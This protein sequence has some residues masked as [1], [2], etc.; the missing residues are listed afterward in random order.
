MV[1]QLDKSSL[2]GPFIRLLLI[3]PLF[4]FH[5]INAT[6]TK[7]IHYSSESLFELLAANFALY[8]NDQEASLH[9]YLS[10][11]RVQ[12]TA[13]IAERA[14]QLALSQKRY[15]AMLE[16]AELW[17]KAS[18]QDGSALFFSSLASALNNKGLQALIYMSEAEKKGHPTDYTRIVKLLNDNALIQKAYRNHLQFV[19][20]PSAKN[21]DAMIALCLLLALNGNLEP[22]P[23]LLEKAITHGKHNPSVFDFAGQLFNRIQQPEKAIAIYQKGVILHPQQLTLRL[24]LAKLAQK[25]D[26]ALAKLQFEILH[27]YAPNNALINKNLGALYLK[28]GNLKQAERIFQQLTTEDNEAVFAKTQLANIALLNNKPDSAL[29]YLSTI[30]HPLQTERIQLSIIKLHIQLSHLSRA[31]KLIKKT[32]KKA[33]SEDFAV[34][35]KVLNIELLE[36]R[37]KH[38]KALK[39]LALYTSQH[40]EYNHFFIKSAT[41]AANIYDEHSFVKHLKQ[42]LKHVDN[43]TF[44]LEDIGR[45]IANQS[46]SGIRTKRILQNALTLAPNNPVLLDTYGWLLY[47]IGFLHDAASWVSRSLA[48]RPKAKTAAHLGEILWK[49][50]DKDRAKR[51]FS[52]AVKLTPNDQELHNTIERLNVSLLSQIST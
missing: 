28:E 51:V 52:Q 9:Y 32:L 21:Y 30:P 2:I 31:K 43:K 41:I 4:L 49:L 20:A 14:T 37:Q 22:I 23:S 15:P 35:L 26:P 36:A 39:K 50:G 1:V 10:Q 11:S 33:T 48:H 5:N 38:K 34:K 44:P 45:R 13:A 18:P 29:K 6:P 42:L 27:L 40:P 19:Y 17:L 3:P 46:S 47:R 12:K 8:R 16:A 25:H 7:T 24:K